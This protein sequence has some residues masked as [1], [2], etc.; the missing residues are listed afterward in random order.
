MKKIIVVVG[1]TGVGKTKLSIALGKYF[2]GEI[3]N[4]DSMQVYRGLNIGTAKVTDFE[5]IKHHLLDIK[6]VTDF[7]S[8][9]DFQRDGRKILDNTDKTVII[10]GGTGL[11]V[12][13]LL[14]NY[15]FINLEKQYDFSELSNKQL[16]EKILSY[17]K[18]IDIHL[19]NRNRLERTLLLLMNDSYQK[20]V[21]NELLYDATF[22]G[23]TTD[24]KHLYKI[25]NDRVDKMIKDGLVNEVKAF[26]DQGIRSKPLLAGIGYKEL[27][28][29]FDGKITLE[30]AIILIKK[31]SRHYAKRQ[32]TW[33]NNQMHIKWFESNFDFFDKTIT[34]V[35][36]YIK[37]GAN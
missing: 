20:K 11:Y 33:F 5:N 30:E 34:A 37:E 8:V 25:I 12:K 1:P 13:A 28:N 23:L 35:I 15:E 3:I 4:A 9:Y 29:H 18:T 24:R 32:Y 21:S 14:Y 7:Y 26:Y 27:Y 22:I 6:D 2:Q 17:N 16:K 31:N 10:V 36:D 19:N